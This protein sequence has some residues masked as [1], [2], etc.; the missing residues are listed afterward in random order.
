[1]VHS[2]FKE[3][4]DG[5]TFVYGS[6]GEYLTPKKIQ[7]I[8]AILNNALIT[9]KRLGISETDIENQNDAVFSDRGDGCG[10]QK[11][12]KTPILKPNKRR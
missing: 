5:N 10:K 6:F 4:K 8:Q 3:T 2:F 11:N 7:E 12:K 9:Y 1:M